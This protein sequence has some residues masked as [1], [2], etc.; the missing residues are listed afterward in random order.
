ML[1]PYPDGRVNYEEWCLGVYNYL[2]WKSTYNLSVY[3]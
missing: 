2:K 3:R 1:N